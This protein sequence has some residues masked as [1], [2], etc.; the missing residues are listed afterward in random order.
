MIK[1]ILKEAAFDRIK[2]S[3]A[4]GTTDVITSD[5]VDMAGYEGC[6]FVVTLGT[7]TSTG[8]VTCKLQQ[9]SDN[10]V[11]DGYSDIEGSS[12]ANSGDTATTKQILIEI[13]NPQKRYLKLLATRATA[14]CG[15]DSITAIKFGA[16]KLPITDDASVDGT[17]QL[18]GPAEGTA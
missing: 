15:I 16:K 13:I 12:K 11:A 5:A 17:L 9:S 8:T 3:Q 10:A 2:V 1:S 6:L 18:V 4:A 7:L 14:N